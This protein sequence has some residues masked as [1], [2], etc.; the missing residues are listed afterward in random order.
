[1]T[2]DKLTQRLEELRKEYQEGEK[3]KQEL[4]QKLNN[5]DTT[6]LRISGAMQ[7]LEELK[8]AEASATPASDTD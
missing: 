7:V 8:P 4:S 2:D 5:I 1:M 3:I 6:L